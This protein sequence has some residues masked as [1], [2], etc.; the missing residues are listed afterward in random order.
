MPYCVVCTQTR[1]DMDGPEIKSRWGRNLLLP[2][3]PAL[4]PAQPPVKWV[5]G[6]VTGGKAA[7]PW[8]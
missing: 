2:S 6:L 8:L 4:G 5:P 7:R 1:N 3:T